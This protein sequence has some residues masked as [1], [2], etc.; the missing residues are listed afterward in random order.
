MSEP[1]NTP[2]AEA[3]DHSHS[4]EAAHKHP[5]EGL[6]V[7]IL[8]ILAMLTLAEVVSAYLPTIRYPLLIGISF[9]KAWLVLRVY[10]HLR[11]ENRLLTF[12]FMAPLIAATIII[13]VIN[14]LIQ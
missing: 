5:A 10:M 11:Y 14:P 1:K 2:A 8:V 4:A 7:S 6:Y 13:V 3:A 12:V 9:G